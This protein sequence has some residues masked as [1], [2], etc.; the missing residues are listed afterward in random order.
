MAATSRKLLQVAIALAGLP[1]AGAGGGARPLSKTAPISVDAASSVV[2]YATHHLIL[3]SVVIAQ[4][5]LRVTAERADA[6]G[7]DF[8]N[9]RWIFSGDVHLSSEFRGNLVSDEAVVEFRDNQI[10]S[11][12][13]TGHPAQFEQTASTT[14]V[15]ARGHADNIQY[16][17]AAGTIR[18]TTDAWLKY[19]DNDEITAP[20]LVYNI[21][22][23][24]LEGSTPRPGQRVHMMIVPKKSAAAPKAGSRPPPKPA[25][26]AVPPAAQSSSPSARGSSP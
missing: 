22:A 19:G 11:A 14:G 13:A 4:D 5:D 1:L 15:L 9:S 24:R 8:Q 6:T 25:P 18:M 17:V 3:K 7:L 2:D 10:Q 12:V 16:A 23:Q 26:K 20:V 21:K